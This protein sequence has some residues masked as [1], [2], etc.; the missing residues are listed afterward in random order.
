MPFYPS[1]D[2]VTAYLGEMTRVNS[3]V[4]L[5]CREMSSPELVQMATRLAPHVEATIFTQTQQGKDFLRASLA[6]AT[7]Q[8]QGSWSTLDIA[9]RMIVAHHPDWQT[10]YA[11]AWGLDRTTSV[12]I[13]AYRER[14]PHLPEGLLAELGADE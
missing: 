2:T 10:H 7:L 14:W 6:T 13:T 12:E 4:D 11:Y 3:P 1:R 8:Q 5:D 9:Q